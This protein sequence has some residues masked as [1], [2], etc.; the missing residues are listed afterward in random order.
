LRRLA[1]DERHPPRPRHEPREFVGER[2]GGAAPPGCGCGSLG[3][4]SG[5]W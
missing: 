4:P 3:G 1:I 2:R 5:L